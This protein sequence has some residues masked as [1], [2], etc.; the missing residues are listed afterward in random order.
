TDPEANAE[1][2]VMCE[3]FAERRRLMIAGLEAAGVE[4]VEPDGAFYVFPDFSALC[5]AGKR[6]ADDLALASYLLEDK[7]LATVPGSAFGA[8][9]HL[10]LS[11]ACSNDDIERGTTA[12][13]EALA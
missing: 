12:L 11:F 4:L 13:R 5:G 7:G 2:T 6:F 1:V 9:G 8:P 3:R 10:R